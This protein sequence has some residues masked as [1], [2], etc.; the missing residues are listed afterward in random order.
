MRI[1]NTS[2]QKFPFGSGDYPDKLLH[3]SPRGIHVFLGASWVL[4]TMAMAPVIALL[5]QCHPYLAW[6]CTAPGR[7]RRG[8]GGRKEQKS[9][10]AAA[11]RWPAIYT[12]HPIF[13]WSHRLLGT[14]SCS[15]L[16]TV[17][18]CAS[19]QESDG[20]QLPC[21]RLLSYQSMEQQP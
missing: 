4:I 15:G 8:R 14:V 16:P 12:Y 10:P 18:A 13:R 19:Q 20:H 17:A 21:G 7:Y 9:G 6:H 11:R 1:T 2:Y 5:L 3:Q